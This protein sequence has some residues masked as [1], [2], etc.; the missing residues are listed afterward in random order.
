MNVRPWVCRPC[1][2]SS[3]GI[4]EAQLGRNGFIVSWLKLHVER[5][6]RKILEEKRKILEEKF[7]IEKLGIDVM[8]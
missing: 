2:T 3:Q 4:C 6:V 8:V 7:P 1:V 5:S